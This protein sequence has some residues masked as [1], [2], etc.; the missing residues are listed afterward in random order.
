MMSRKDLVLGMRS[1]G[2]R[3]GECEG[4]G[5]GEGRGRRKG[6]ERKATRLF[7]TQGHVLELWHHARAD[8][9]CAE[10]SKRTHSTPFYTWS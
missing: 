9:S 2:H 6:K 1:G 10:E 7:D 8:I 3:G 5:E 4:E